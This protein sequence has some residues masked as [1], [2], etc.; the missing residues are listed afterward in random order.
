MSCPRSRPIRSR[1]PRSPKASPATRARRRAISRMPPVRV[2]ED[3]EPP[4]A[5]LMAVAH[6]LDALVWQREVCKL[7]TIFGGRNPHPNF[8]VGGM[9]S[10]ISVQSPGAQV[11]PAHFRGGDAATAVNVLGLQQVQDIINMMRTFV[12]EVY[13]PD[14]LAIA[15]F[16][17]D[18]AKVGEGL[19]NF[20]CYGDLPAKSIRD[21]SSFL[22]P[23]GAIVDRDLSH[24]QPVD[25]H[26]DGEIQEYIAHSWYTTRKVRTRAFTRTPAKPRFTTPGRSRRTRTWTSTRLTR[27]SSRRGGRA[28]RWRSARLRAC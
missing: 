2:R 5:N 27:G 26:A 13:V 25:L 12:N 1:P 28:G 3:A 16:Y 6:Y 4:E 23:R 15:G 22:F 18:W 14:T 9:P 17:K 8:L 7:H 10:A 21:P 11:E 20:L 19:G 24:I